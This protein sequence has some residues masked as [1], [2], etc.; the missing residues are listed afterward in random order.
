MLLLLAAF[1]TVNIVILCTDD[2]NDK[3]KE[4]EEI[5]NQIQEKEKIYSEYI[6]EIETLS[7][8][9]LAE[10]LE[11]DELKKEVVYLQEKVSIQNKE[12]IDKKTYYSRLLYD[13]FLEG[14]NQNSF[15][16]FKELPEFYYDFSDAERESV[17]SNTASTVLGALIGEIGTTVLMEKNKQEDK[18]RISALI[19]FNLKMQKYIDK[20]AGVLN[21]ILEIQNR[22]GFYSQLADE[23]VSAENVRKLSTGLAGRI[24]GDSITVNDEI[25]LTALKNIYLAAELV[26]TAYENILTENEAAIS[27][28]NRWKLYMNDCNELNEGYYS[29]PEGILALKDT[30]SENEGELYKY[31]TELIAAYCQGLGD[32]R[33]S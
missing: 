12:N 29:T 26:Y 19:D 33:N 23:E 20:H 8:K 13:A 28:I 22:I 16:R 4:K 11:T 10:S 30:M 31:Y 27:E 32:K 5:G 24:E 15:L 14:N 21:D 2:C 3:Q 17:E 7:D 6:N 9:V 1:T 25:D 18:N